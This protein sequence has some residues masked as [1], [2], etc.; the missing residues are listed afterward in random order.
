KRHAEVPESRS[1]T[2]DVERI[3]AVVCKSYN[4]TKE[5][6][7]ATRRGTANEARD[8]AVYLMTYLKGIVLKKL[9]G[10]FGQ[11]RIAR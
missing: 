10:N 11:P 3:R 6:L 5:A 1:L 9:P 7:T 4:V 8:V 2:P